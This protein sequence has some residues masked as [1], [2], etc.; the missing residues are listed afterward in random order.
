MAS[1][2]SEVFDDILFDWKTEKFDFVLF[3]LKGLHQ[4]ELCNKGKIPYDTSK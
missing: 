3:N 4:Y 2:S 1:Q